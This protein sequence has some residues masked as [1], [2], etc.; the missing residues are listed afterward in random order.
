MLRVLAGIAWDPQLRGF[1]SVA[2]GVVVL[3]GSIYLLLV[4]NVGTRLGFLIASASFWGWLF[5]MGAIWWVYGTIGMLGVAPHWVVNETLY[6][7]GEAALPEVRRLDTSAMPPPEDLRNIDGADLEEVREEVE[8]TLNGWRILPEADPSFGEAKATVDE[9]FSEHNDTVLELDGADDYLTVYAFE[10][11]GKDALPSDPSR[12][13]R[14]T[15]FLKTTFWQVTHPTRYAVVQVHPV[16]EQ[17]PGP[18]EAPPTPEPDPDKPIVTVV[19]E[20]DLGDVRFP[21]AMVTI[22]GGLMFG[23]TCAMLHRRDLLAAQARGLLP[24]TAGD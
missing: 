14:I 3:I 10:R 19:M 23:V 15:T 9:H 21:A 7:T 20:R 2:V 6:S 13:D 22:L 1:L 17:T 4:T 8:P 5:L 18:G 12:I 24:A 11:G 16:I